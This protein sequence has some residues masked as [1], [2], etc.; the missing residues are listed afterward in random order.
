V[1]LAEAGVGQLAE[2]A[3]ETV[4]GLGAELMGQFPPIA[5]VARALG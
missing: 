3:L 2:A 1:L 4:G 5:K